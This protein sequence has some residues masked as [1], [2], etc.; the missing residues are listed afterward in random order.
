[1]SAS[2]LITVKYVRKRTA[3]LQ[4][5][6]GHLFLHGQPVP[7]SKTFLLTYAI[8]PVISDIQQAYKLRKFL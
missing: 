6:G 4:K 7:L 2:A 3:G 8:R 1:M 5:H